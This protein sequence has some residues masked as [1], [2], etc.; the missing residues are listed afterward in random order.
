MAASLAGAGAGGNPVGQIAHRLP[1]EQIAKRGAND[2]SSRFDRLMERKN[3]AAKPPAGVNP[4]QWPLPSARAERI[5]R[6]EQ[7][8]RSERTSVASG[9]ARAPKG[10]P[11]RQEVSRVTSTMQKVVEDLERGQGALDKLIN[12]SLR[13]KQFSQTELLALQASMYKYS[14]E[15]DLTSKVVEKATNGLKDTLKTQV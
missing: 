7:V 1:R 9:P 6:V 2:A 14:Q 5:R 4:A 13:R 3:S 10:A 11:S 15:L 8:G 12:G